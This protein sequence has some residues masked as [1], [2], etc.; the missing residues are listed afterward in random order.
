MKYDTSNITPQNS[1]IETPKYVGGYRL[2]DGTYSMIFN[3]TKKPCWLHRKCV[4]LILGWKWID[5]Q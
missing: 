4:E 3:L 5:G 1:P 2:G